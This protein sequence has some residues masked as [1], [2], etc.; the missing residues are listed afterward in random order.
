MLL[1]AAFAPDAHAGTRARQEI[2]AEAGHVN[3]DA[4]FAFFPNTN[5]AADED[6][7]FRPES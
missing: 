4:N 1:A 6:L 3:S 7:T 2:R 5:R